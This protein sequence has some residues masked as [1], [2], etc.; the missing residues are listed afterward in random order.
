MNEAS[1]DDLNNQVN[2]FIR[3]IDKGNIISDTGS[4]NVIYLSDYHLLPFGLP[5][6]K[7]YLDE[8]H[9][10]SKSLID[11]ALKTHTNATTE[12]FN[13]YW[14]WTAALVSHLSTNGEIG[15]Y[16]DILHDFYFLVHSSLVSARH[17]YLVQNNQQ[18]LRVI[19]RTNPSIEGVTW[20][21]GLPVAATYGFSVLEGLL[22]RRC[23][24]FETNDRIKIWEGLKE[25]SQDDDVSG[26]VKE[27][28][29][30]VDDLDR[31]DRDVLERKMEGVPELTNRT[32]LSWLITKQRNYNI[33]GEG[34]TQA[35]GS[36]VLTLCS[37]VLLDEIATVSSPYLEIR[38]DVFQGIQRA[39]QSGRIHPMGPAAFYPVK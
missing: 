10:F 16:R 32:R 39:R 2:E 33:H 25:L 5:L 17:S 13:A 27:V 14:G 38:K 6:H 30:E 15:K 18:L 19:S 8:L 1:R 24:V 4:E 3:T 28:L 26:V 20:G 23:R 11:S 35:I 36:I 22:K 37:L 29:A 9:Y 21:S 7:F 31:Y 12:D 34:S